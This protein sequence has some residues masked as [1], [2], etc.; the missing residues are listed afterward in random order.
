MSDKVLLDKEGLRNALGLKGFGG[1]ILAGFLYRLIGLGK[2]NGHYENIAELDGPAFSYAVLKEMGISYDILKEQEGYIPSEGGF[3]TVSNHP[4]GGAEGLILNALIGSKRPDFKILTTFLLAKVRNLSSW[5]IPVDNF[6]SAGTKSITGIREALGH[7]DSGH[8]L[9]LFPAGEVSTWQDKKVVEDKPW[10]DNI[11]KIIKNSG[12]PVVPVYFDGCNSTLFHRLGRIHPMLRTVR[13]VR[14]LMNKKGMTIKVRIGKPISK[15]EVEGM[16]LKTLGKYLRNRCYA[17]E[18]QCIPVTSNTSSVEM[19]DLSAPADQDSVRSQMEAQEGNILFQTGDYRAYLIDADDA[20]AVMKELYR[21]REETFRSIGEGTGKALDTD[22]YDTYYK[23]LILWHIKNRDIVGSYRVGYGS[24]ILPKHGIDGLYT[25]SLLKYGP[26]ADDVLPHAM[27]L[28]RSFVA[29]KYQREVLPLKLMLA[30]LTVALIN[31]P[32]CN[33]CI[34]TVSISDL[35]PDF[36]KSLGIYFIE[37]DL[38][39]HEG[40]RFAKAP[41]P[42]K[43]DYLRVDP[44]SLLCV[45]PKGNIDAYDKLQ[46]SLSDGKYRLPVLFRKY[47]SCGARVACFNVDPSFNNCV[48]AMIVLKM[49]DFPVHMIRSI[50]RPLDKDMQEKVFLRFYGTTNPS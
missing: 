2:L 44:E 14:E 47:F 3:I 13:L 45:V 22:S 40:E 20:P 41:N 32:Q 38:H 28:G 5:F 33:C 9:G 6:S 10:A 12:L 46:S 7:L 43:P 48:D 31:D 42:F 21:L 35:L 27:E 4:F 37:R 50:V 11:I 39:L 8:P 1:N 30:G 17:L 36:Y 25:A 49:K 15:D 23:H 18:S 34:G 24:E 29:L 26:A 16:D 19:E